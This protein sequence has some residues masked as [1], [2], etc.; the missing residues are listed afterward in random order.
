MSISIREMKKKLKNE[1][2][3]GTFVN[4]SAY[5]ALRKYA[6][7][8]LTLVCMETARVFRESDDRKVTDSHVMLAV[9]QMEGV[10]QV[11]TN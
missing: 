11:D 7:G 5:E 3:G 10:E 8:M 2:E 9:L 1:L 6:D 4:D